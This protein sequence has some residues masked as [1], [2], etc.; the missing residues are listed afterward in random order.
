MISGKNALTCSAGLKDAPERTCKVCGKTFRTG[1]QYA[2]KLWSSEAHKKRD[3]YCSYSCY[4]TVT[5]PLEEQ[6][7]AQ[8]ERIQRDAVESEDRRR[9]YARVLYQRQK[10]RKQ[11]QTKATK[12]REQKQNETIAQM[13]ARMKRESERRKERAREKASAD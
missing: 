8:F 4:R 3:W 9:E 6:Q 5:K 10:K 2:Y 11:R 13:I 1:E 7:K 12:E